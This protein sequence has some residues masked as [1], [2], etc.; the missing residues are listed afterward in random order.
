MWYRVWGSQDKQTGWIGYGSVYLLSRESSR[1]LSEMT[2]GESLGLSL[3]RYK[4]E[5]VGTLG[6]VQNEDVDSN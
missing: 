6:L 2:S 4:F 3:G 5:V 1:V